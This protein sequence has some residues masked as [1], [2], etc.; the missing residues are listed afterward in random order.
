MKVAPH[1]E[2]RHSRRPELVI[3]TPSILHHTS[4][5]TPPLFPL[6]PP[7]P[8]P[9]PQTPRDD[10]API[11]VPTGKAN[12]V[13]AS[14]SELTAII[15]PCAMLMPCHPFHQRP[16]GSTWFSIDLGRGCPCHPRHAPRH[17]LPSKPDGLRDGHP[18]L[19]HQ[20]P[21]SHPTY[22]STIR[23]RPRNHARAASL[24]RQRLQSTRI[25]MSSIP[26]LTPAASLMHAEICP[27]PRARGDAPLTLSP[28]RCTATTSCSSAVSSFCLRGKVRSMFVILIY[29]CD[30][31]DFWFCIDN[32]AVVCMMDLSSPCSAHPA[33]HHPSLALSGV[34]G[35]PMLDSG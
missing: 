15:A 9:P 18:H 12:S 23:P 35:V 7:R 4:T 6:S 28:G 25:Q 14:V 19:P 30:L 20:M 26:T 16:R 34:H 8:S 27:P 24:S 17:P 21:R 5:P 13:C 1:P 2:L 10:R 32:S 29:V 11:V 22:P 3:H 33:S 31:G